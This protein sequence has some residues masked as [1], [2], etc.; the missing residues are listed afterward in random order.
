[1]TLPLSGA[2]GRKAGGRDT[3]R[4]WVGIGDSYWKE[5]GHSARPGRGDQHG[6]ETPPQAEGQGRKIAEFM[7]NQTALE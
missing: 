2:R 7:A 1:M 6:G 3:G 5:Q 4:G